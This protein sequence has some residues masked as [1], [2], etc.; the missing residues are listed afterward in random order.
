MHWLTPPNNP[1]IPCLQTS[2]LHIV[3]LSVYYELYLQVLDTK[4]TSE[5][6]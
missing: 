1:L 3:Q 2:K 4:W 5:E 6:V